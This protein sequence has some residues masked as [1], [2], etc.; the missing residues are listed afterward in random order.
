[1]GGLVGFAILEIG[2]VQLRRAGVVII[3]PLVPQRFEIQEVSG[4]FLD[5]PFAFGLSGEDFG[6]QSAHGFGQAFR[7]SAKP[8]E[9]FGRRVRSRAQAQTCDR[10]SGARSG[11]G[12]MVR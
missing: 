12:R 6:R 1:M 2:G 8:L 10:T 11:I 7:G 5:R 3:E 4:I 9:K